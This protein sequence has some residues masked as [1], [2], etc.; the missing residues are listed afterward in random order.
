MYPDK[1]A[2]CQR[3]RGPCCPPR[4]RIWFRCQWRCACRMKRV[5]ARKDEL[6]GRWNR[7]VAEWLRVLKNCTVIKGHARFQSSHT[8]AGNDESC[9]PT[10]FSSTLAAAAD[11]SREPGI[12]DVPFLTNSSMM[13][14]DFLPKHLVIVGGSYIGLEF[15]QMYRRFG[16]EVTYCRKASCLIGREDEYF[17]S[18]ARNPGY[19]GDTD[20]PNA[21]LYHWRSVT[22]VSPSASQCDEGPPELLGTHVLPAVGSTP[23]T[24]DLGLTGPVSRPTNAATS[25]LT[26]NCKRRCPASGPWVTAMAVV[27]LRIPHITLRHRRGQSPQRR[28]LPVIRPNPDLRFV[29]TPPLGRCGMTGTEIR[30]SG[31]G[32]LAVEHPIAELAGPLK[33]VRHKVSSKSLLMRK[34]DRFRVRR[35]LGPEA[36]K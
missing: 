25:S 8:V 5:K 11:C 34:Q 29:Y 7:G 1:D 28:P 32:A 16:S 36:M 14:V 21:T 26:I 15:G 4:C 20:W 27:H 23:D 13:D 9:K 19:R 30:T 33:K 3:L 35:F 10:K 12:Q 18:R 6:S 17:R 2:R 22:A 24:N 31:C